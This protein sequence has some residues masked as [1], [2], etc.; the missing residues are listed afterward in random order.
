VSNQAVPNP[1]ES[2][3]PAFGQADLTNCERELIHL[4]G[5]VQPHGLMLAL[6]EPDLRIV[7]ASANVQTLLGHP[8]EQLLN[9]PVAELGGDIDA[10]IRR[11]CAAATDLADPSPLRCTVQVGGTPREFEGTLHRVL[12]ATG[13]RVLLVEIEPVGARQG[14]VDTVD[15]PTPQLRELVG[16]AVQRLSDAAS[17][18]TLA[19]GVVRCFRDMLGY[20]RV[21]VY[22]FDPDGHGKI[23]AEARD[24]RLASLLGHHYPATDIPQRA[25]E[26]YLRNRLRVLVDVHYVPSPLVPRQLPGTGEELDM[27]MCQLRSMSPLH[28][29]YLKNMGVTATLVVSLV[30]EGRLWGL[31]ACHHDTPRNLRFAVRAA[32]DLLAEVAAT[33]IA[34]IE[35]Y[36]HAQVA[37]QVRR[38]EQRL[39]EATSTEGDWRLAL[40]RNPRT[41]LQPLDATGAALF[42]EG[43]LLTAGEVPSTAELR[44][45]LQWIDAQPFDGLFSCSSVARANP[46]LESLTSTASGVLAV[47]LSVSSPDYLV[48]FRK[49]QLLTVTWA[50]DPSKP[51]VAKNPL[52]LSPRSSF[53]AW[54]EIVRGTALPWSNSELALGRAFGASLVDIIVQI[55]AVRLLIAEHQLAQV[56]STVG[57][58]AEPVVI[59]NVGG[60]TLFANQAFSKLRGHGSATALDDLPG[61]FAETDLVR[62]LLQSLAHERQPWRGELGLRLADGGA[63]PVA[64]R[65]E[66]VPARDGSVLGFFMIVTDLADTQRAVEARRHLEL[67]L[68]QAVDSSPARDGPRA[69]GTNAQ[70]DVMGAI[71]ANASVAAM[72]IADGGSAATM[73]PLLV[74]LEQSTRRAA[75][76][77]GRMNLFGA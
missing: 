48:W 63:L 36:A 33:R 59:G 7:Q 2:I 10:A 11:A 32:A 8:V 62:A 42:H 26:L 5:S 16:A 14:E 69:A 68:S 35:N 17:I 6:R 52:E 71:L 25:R 28:L 49:E 70:G 38:L 31:I 58:A 73:A 53:A 75:Q 66:V 47:K 50:G 67:S 30:R 61:L 13:G 23:I 22:K 65:A 37:I 15:I 19:D 74:E 21:M 60:R 29:Q 77:Y 39:V 41:V 46:A 24:P 43:E 12:T 4:A 20:D 40:F 34:A 1:A 76:L 51:M 45:L 56:R 27:S 57:N 72:D 18:G 55:N 64:V 3:G 54:S 9:Q 44:T